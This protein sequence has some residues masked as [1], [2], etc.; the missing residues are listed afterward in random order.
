MRRA[1]WTLGVA[2]ERTQRERRATSERS[3]VASGTKPSRRA[4]VESTH[5]HRARRSRRVADH[6]CECLCSIHS[7]GAASRRVA[8]PDRARFEDQT[9]ARPQRQ[10]CAAESHV[11]VTKPR[12]ASREPRRQSPK[13]PARR[14]KSQT[15][16]GACASKLAAAIVRSGLELSA[17]ESR[18]TRVPL[19]GS[20]NSYG[21][22]KGRRGN[23]VP[24]PRS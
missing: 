23:A 3:I 5:L 24:A 7:R 22:K 18:E 12:V 9:S 20:P 16:R 10:G 19:P 6:P 1:L 21:S 13:R 11:T 8:E 14:T 15:K 17:C 2:V 4:S